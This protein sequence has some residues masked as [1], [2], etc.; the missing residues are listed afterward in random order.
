MNLNFIR[1]ILTGLAGVIP[2]LV[3]FFGCTPDA[4]T[5]AVSCASS[6]VPPQYSLLLAGVLGILSFVLKMFGQGGTMAEN[7]AKPSVV[8]TPEAKAG[9]VT[10]AQVVSVKK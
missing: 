1:S 2:V 8:V 5:G 10:E 3:V 9:T 7:L 6:W 4:V